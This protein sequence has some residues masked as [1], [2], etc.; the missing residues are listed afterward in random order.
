[1]L[2]SST[3]D[4]RLRV[5][6]FHAANCSDYNAVGAAIRLHLTKLKH[7]NTLSKAESSVCLYV[8]GGSSV[9]PAIWTYDGVKE[10]VQMMTTESKLL[11]S[12]PGFILP[13]WIDG[14]LQPIPDISGVAG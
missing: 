11:R 1:M 9:I 4:N 12:A 7:S 5:V 10:E 2:G 8:L 13:A 3:G 14:V 6:M